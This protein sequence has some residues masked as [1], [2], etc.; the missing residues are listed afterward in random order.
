ME[1]FTTKAR[2]PTS[3]DHG[4][5]GGFV[6]ADPHGAAGAA[7]AAGGRAT[8]MS[9]SDPIRRPPPAGTTESLRRDIQRTRNALAE[10]LQELNDRLNPRRV[11]RR[12][13]RRL[14]TAP[15]P[16]IG[17]AVVFGAV[18]TFASLGRPGRRL[19]PARAGV[20]GGIAAV[21]T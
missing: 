2:S 1:R 19:T 12:G 4:G 14:R 13:L 17:A 11:A 20:A 9:T 18:A 21:G 10:T 6:S 15:V 7:M 3:A 5:A 8:T 16:I